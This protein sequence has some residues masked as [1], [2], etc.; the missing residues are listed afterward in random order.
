M[1]ANGQENWRPL[2]V[3]KAQ[4]A[5][6]RFV[7]K[8][9]GCFAMGKKRLSQQ[10]REG[11]GRGGIASGSDPRP[12]DE[13]RKAWGDAFEKVTQALA[14]VLQELASGEQRKGH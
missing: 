6:N 11:E 13:L 7:K 2:G 1:I 8:L 14:Q 9:R 3:I 5:M 10:P 12:V 4:A